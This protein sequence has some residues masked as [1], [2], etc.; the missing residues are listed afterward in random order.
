LPVSSGQQGRLSAV[1]PQ[2][3]YM[4][5]KLRIFIDLVLEALGA[6]E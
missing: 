5:A 4:P 1:W 6:Q 3:R 2:G